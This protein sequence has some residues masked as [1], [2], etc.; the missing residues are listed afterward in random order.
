MSSGV[1]FGQSRTVCLSARRTARAG[2][3][4]SLALSDS[5][6]AREVGAGPGPQ[7]RKG[8]PAQGVG[9]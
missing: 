7:G 3:W 5:A 4:R 6:A 2:L 1:G 8:G 9:S